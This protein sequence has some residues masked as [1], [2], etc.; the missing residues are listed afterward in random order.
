VT[1]AENP[2]ATGGRGRLLALGALVLGVGGALLW[3][4]VKKLILDER[5]WT[6][7]Q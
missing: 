3:L 1:P 5:P 6:P 7:V 4:V 2:P